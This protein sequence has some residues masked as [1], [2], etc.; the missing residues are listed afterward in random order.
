[1]NSDFPL[2]LRGDVFQH[3]LIETLLDHKKTPM[4]GKKNNKEKKEKK[5]NKDHLI[6]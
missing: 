3:F 2:K 4:K 6:S 5:K 1:M